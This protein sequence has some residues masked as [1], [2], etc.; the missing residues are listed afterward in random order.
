M[1]AEEGDLGRAQRWLEA[2][3]T[4][5]VC[6]DRDFRFVYVNAAAAQLVEVPRDRLLGSTQWEVFPATL[7]TELE[8]A[9]RHAMSTGERVVFEQYWPP[10][11]LWYRLDVRPGPDGLDVA[12]ADVTES[13][14]L[15]DEGPAATAHEAQALLDLLTE[16]SAALSATLDIDEAVHRLARLVVPRL[17]DWCIVS[18]RTPGGQLTDLAV[19]HRDPRLERVAAR[20][21]RHRVAA[22]AP[23][24]PA[25]R[26]LAAREVIT[27][28]DGRA[29]SISELVSRLVTT[30][31]AR[32]LVTELAPG[33]V[34]SVPLLS[35]GRVIGLL[36]LYRDAG[37]PGWTAR[38]L[39]AAVD[40]AGRAGTAVET[41]R[42][43]TEAALLAEGLQRSLL[44]DPPE[45]EH[46]EIA[47]RYLPAV[48][49]AQVG[50]DW[51]DAF[52]QPG[53]TTML[54]I[55]DVV[56]HDVQAAAA[57][58]QLRSLLRGIA[59]HSDGGPA[60]VLAGLDRA[61]AV[62]GVHTLATAAVARFEQ[63]DGER[64]RGLVRLR[65][66]NA[67]HLPP[68]AIH[69]DGSVV[70]LGGWRADLLLGVDPGAPRRESVL[71]LDRGS[72]VFFFTDGLVEDRRTD[73]DAGVARLRAALTEFAALP[74]Q[75]LCDAVL[76]R[77]V[78]G[79]PDDDV[80]LVAV[81]LTGHSPDQ[82][83]PA[84]VAPLPAG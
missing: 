46:A 51:Y 26:A 36:S 76:D 66:S 84:D 78:A 73:L 12:F 28:G 23:G 32:R 69:P 15:G 72:T 34:A 57:M 44:T 41:A 30:P 63:D 14:R 61:M 80:A 45:P 7:G 35:G 54:V 3:E 83:A 24:A 53:G 40:V 50:G 2:S 16:T 1:A 48:E 67:G 75:E 19:A 71:T 10:Q 47:V 55:G 9:Y 5:L 8:R 82:G 59:T 52:V 38:E 60:E 64:D 43:Y 22:I 81:R 77:L 49:A 79:R 6:F 20:Y 33:W 4:G 74:L 21:A 58:G 65:W 17:A 18:S 42:L 29:E 11:D 70:V 31:T 27:V 68:L 37:R 62:L 56:G 39:S 25:H 13:K